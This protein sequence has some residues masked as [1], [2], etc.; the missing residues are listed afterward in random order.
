MP[1]FLDNGGHF[2]SIIIT[3][4]SQISPEEQT[5]IYE[6]VSWQNIEKLLP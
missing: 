6:Q 2:Y 5:E 1:V 4:T 3:T